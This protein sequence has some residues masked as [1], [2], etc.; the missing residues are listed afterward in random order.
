M[1]FLDYLPENRKNEEFGDSN[2]DFIEVSNV[3]DKIIKVLLD[4][5]SLGVSEDFFISFESLIKIGKKAKSQILSFIQTQNPNSFIRDLLYLILQY[6]NEGD[7]DTPLIFHLYHPD[8]VIRAK[9]I[10]EIMDMEKDNYFKYIIPL[11]DDPDDSVR[12]QVLKYFISQEL[13]PNPIIKN[14][15]R[16][17]LNKELNPIII[18]KIKEI[19]NKTS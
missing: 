18:N 7:I 11:I 16:K 15:L 5:L 17:R 3:N 10:K 12:F 1:N 13:I 2:W 4:K 14:Q 8:F 19:L 6:I 9:S